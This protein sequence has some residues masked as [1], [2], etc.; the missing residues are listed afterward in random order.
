MDRR[1]SAGAA[2]GAASIS[3][4]DTSGVGIAIVSSTWSKS[5][6][7]DVRRRM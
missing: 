5:G 4:G 3:A 6:P 7:V 1:G 2:V